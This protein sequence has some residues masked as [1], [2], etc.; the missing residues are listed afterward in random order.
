MVGLYFSAT[1]HRG[2]CEFTTKLVEFY[3]KIKGKGENLEIVLVTRDDEEEYFKQGF[4]TMPWLALP[5]KDKSCE[6]LVRYFEIYKE[7]KAKDEAFE[8]IFLSSDRE[9]SSFDDFFS[10]MPWLA[11]PFGDER[12]TSLLEKF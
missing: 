9:Q 7:I 8:V 5:F 3:K 11:L 6:K 4:D 10:G 2:C 1:A 12:K